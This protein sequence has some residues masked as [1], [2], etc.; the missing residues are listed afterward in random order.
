MKQKQRRA[1][2]PLKSKAREYAVTNFKNYTFEDLAQYF[3]TPLLDAATGL[4]VSETYLK[5]LCRVFNIHRWPYRRLQSLQSQRDIILANIPFIPKRA[6]QMKE[7]VNEIEE[8]IKYI[9]KNGLR[10]EGHKRSR[11]RV[12]AG[13]K[14]RSN[15]PK[16][17]RCK[18]EESDNTNEQE[19]IEELDSL[20]VQDDV[21]ENL[22]LEDLQLKSPESQLVSPAWTV[23]PTVNQDQNRWWPQDSIA[24]LGFKLKL[25]VPLVTVLLNSSFI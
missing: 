21:M 2:G 13:I 20:D 24:P 9:E 15:K 3:N 14:K 8:E 18:I 5:K 4:G 16:T 10:Q 11:V 1:V 17:V 19:H 25:D 22:K 6:D 23:Q 7:K 12:V